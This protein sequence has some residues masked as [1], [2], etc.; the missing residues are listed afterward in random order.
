MSDHVLVTG[1]SGFLGYHIVNAAI[2]KGLIVYAAVRKNSNIKH[3]EDLPVRYVYLD[4][5]NVEDLAKQLRENNI[6]HIIHAAG[7]TKAMRQDT[8]D[9]INATFTLNLAKAAEKLGDQFSKFVFISSLAAVGPLTDPAK[10][11]L[12][13]NTPKPVT[14][15]GRSKL[16]AEKNLSGV[17]ISSVILR[18]T[19]IYGPRDKDIF[20]L[21]KTVNKGFDP[22]IGKFDQFLS[23][24]HAKDVAELAV[25]SLFIP[26]A[27]GIYNVTDG[28]SYNRYQF[29]D[30]IKTILKK[31]AFR[32]HIPMPIVRTL[33]FVLET[34]NGWLKKPSVLS[35]EKLHE[36]AAKN[37]ICDISKA[38]NEL[39]Y[40]PKFDL[41]T[42]LEDSI[43]WYTKNKWM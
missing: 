17:G 26:E 24:V 29:S 22:Y 8:Y 20:I 42:G 4:Y 25:Q 40:S 30:I 5:E 34:T 10:Q 21:V 2:E 1:A 37:W 35:R 13:T 3:L 31:T 39:R 11:I 27:S 19:A 23:F 14:A 12:E 36:L 16:L 6:R 33:A 7:I 28:H 41:Q 38:K 32:F 15:Y 9:Y 18:P 43:A